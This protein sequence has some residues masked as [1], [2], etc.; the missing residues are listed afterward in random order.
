MVDTSGLFGRRIGQSPLNKT[1]VINEM[2]HVSDING[3]YKIDQP[4]IE[5]LLL[6]QYVVGFYA[7]MNNPCFMDLIQGL[8]QLAR[9]G[10]KVV[11]S[12]LSLCLDPF[13]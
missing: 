10:E 6:N 13:I 3:G 12:N 8:S 1:A 7:A 5:G 2:T 9:Y 11:K 4:D